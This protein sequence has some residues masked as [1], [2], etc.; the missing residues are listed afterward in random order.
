MRAFLPSFSVVPIHKSRHA[1]ARFRAAA[2]THQL[3]AAAANLEY[4]YEALGIR[5][6]D[7]R[8][9]PTP[10]FSVNLVFGLH[11]IYH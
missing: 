10:L 6:M 3:A 8:L 5:G 7:A 1:S 9:P 2:C 11:I 4:Y